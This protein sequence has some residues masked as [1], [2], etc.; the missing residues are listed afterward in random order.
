MSEDFFAIM[1]IAA[2]GL[3]AGAGIGI[4][5][6]Y[7]TKNQK[8]EWCLMSS[9]EQNINIALILLFCAVCCG[10]LGYYSFR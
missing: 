8:N 7:L 10:I 1:M 6:G 3:L 5:T 9:K 4:M 2:L